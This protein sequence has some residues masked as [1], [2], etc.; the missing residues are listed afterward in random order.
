MSAEK[1]GGNDPVSTTPLWHGCIDG[2]LRVDAEE[3][4]GSERPRIL[5]GR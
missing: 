5:D 4:Y 1:K 2:A 3:L